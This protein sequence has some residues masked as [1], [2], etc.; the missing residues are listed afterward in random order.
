MPFEGRVGR[1]QRA[2]NSRQQGLDCSQRAPYGSNETVTIERYD[3]FR[4]SSTN[5]DP[6]MKSPNIQR[7]LAIATMALGLVGTSAAADITGAG[8]TFPYPVY[9]K[10]AEG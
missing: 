4:N 1:G 7:F 6:P 2:T 10:W 9:S 8:A 3:G 5:G